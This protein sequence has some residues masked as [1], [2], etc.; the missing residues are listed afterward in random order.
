VG[1]KGTSTS[2][3]TMWVHPMTNDRR[4]RVLLDY[5][6]FEASAGVTIFIFSF[7]VVTQRRFCLVRD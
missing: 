7:W 2:K 5:V 3:R 1:P 4:Y 6:R